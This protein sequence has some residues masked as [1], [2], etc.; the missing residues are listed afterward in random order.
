MQLSSRGKAMDVLVGLV[1]DPLTLIPVRNLLHHMGVNHVFL[2]PTM[3]PSQERV[4]HLMCNS[5]PPDTCPRVPCLY[6]SPSLPSL[7]QA[8]GGRM[9]SIAP[10]VGSRFIGKRS[11]SHSPTRHV[12]RRVDYTSI[13]TY[14]P[15][16]WMPTALSSDMHLVAGRHRAQP[17]WFFL[18]FTPTE[19]EVMEFVELSHTAH[20][21]PCN[22]NIPM[23]IACGDADHQPGNDSPRTA[24]GRARG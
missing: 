24:Q 4:T 1:G 23:D 21:P 8:H 7:M 16:Q 20:S 5:L 14:L 15:P 19:E 10:L 3:P 12:P 11:Y 9:E 2:H 17:W 13:I 6:L 18:H 22:A